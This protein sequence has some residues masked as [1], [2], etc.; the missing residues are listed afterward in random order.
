MS[1]IPWNVKKIKELKLTFENVT[2]MVID[3]SIIKSIDVTKGDEYNKISIELERDFNKF[4]YEGYG[5]Q[6]INSEDKQ[7]NLDYLRLAEFQ[8]ITNIE[9]CYDNNISESLDFRFDGE[10]SNSCQ[11]TIFTN[12]SIK[13]LFSDKEEN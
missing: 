10:H 7:L 1:E 4:K 13:L 11:S 2:G 9:L 8:D 3:G 12:N 6:I 5:E